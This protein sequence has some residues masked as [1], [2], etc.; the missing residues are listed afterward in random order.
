LNV[1][2]MEENFQVRYWMQRL[3]VSRN[4]LGLAVQA[5][6]SDPV[7]VERFIQRAR[8]RCSSDAKSKTFPLAAT[9]ASRRSRRPAACVAS[10]PEQLLRLQYVSRAAADLPPSA[11]QDIVAW[12]DSFNA[13]VGIT[14]ALIATRTHFSQVLEGPAPAVQALMASIAGDARHRDVQMLYESPATR[15]RFGGWAMMLVEDAGLEPLIGELWWA[16][17]VDAPR[18]VRLLQHLLYHLRWEPADEGT[19]KP[20]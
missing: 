5:V 3:S 4:A 7:D 11:V 19:P 17:R 10:P 15:R 9:S 20:P 13:R 1:I 12:S 8:G 2:Q 16:R 14:S 18:A 6:G